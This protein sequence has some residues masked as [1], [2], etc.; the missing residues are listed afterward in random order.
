MLALAV[1]A[2]G[3]HRHATVD[4]QPAMVRCLALPGQYLLRT[5][6]LRDQHAAQQV[7]RLPIASENRRQHLDLFLDLQI[8]RSSVTMDRSVTGIAYAFRMNRRA[9]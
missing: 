5:N 2:K 4:D 1:D 3:L 9:G 7:R 8:L 6:L